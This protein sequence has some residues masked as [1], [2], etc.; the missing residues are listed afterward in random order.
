MKKSSLPAWIRLEKEYT[1]INDFPS[2]CI[3]FVYHVKF[4]DGTMYIGKKNLYS[5]R[6]VKSEQNRNKDAVVDIK[7]RNTG[8]GFRQRYDV[9]RIESNWKSYKGSSKEVKGKKPVSRTILAF[10]Y[11]KLDL[12]YLEEKYLFQY[13]VL[14]DPAYLNSN[15]GGRYYKG[16]VSGEKLDG[17]E[18]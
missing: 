9:V 2:G 7:F 14:T 17:K 18:N 11:T 3:G 13:D 16:A 6:K 5:V 4:D 10:A 1:S 12:T 15:I 8:K